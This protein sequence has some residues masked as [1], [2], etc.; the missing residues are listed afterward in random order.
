MK[1]RPVFA[2]V[3]ANDKLSEDTYRAKIYCPEI[4]CRSSAGK[5]ISILCSDLVLRR[6]FSISSSDGE[7]IHIIYKIK[8]AGTFYLS[9]INPG[10]QLNIHGPLGSGFNITNEKAL[11]VGA[12]VG[13]APLIYLSESLQDKNIDYKL[14]AGFQTIIN[15]HELNNDKTI[16]ITEDGTTTCK[17][18]ITEYIDRIIQEFSPQKIYSCGPEIVMK[19]VVKSAIK[20]NIPVETALERKF[21]CGTG[22]CMGC[23]V[24]IKQDGEEINKRI[25]KDGP[26]FNGRTVVW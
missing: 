13:I 12:G 24:K 4:A 1:K 14:L 18:R 15:I 10:K 3:T 19:S 22:V 11:L 8:G 26:V 2:R 16:V 5:F 23:V 25:C 17:G 9:E 7:N 21:A 20:H 6:P